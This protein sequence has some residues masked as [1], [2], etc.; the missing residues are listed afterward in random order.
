MESVP[1][2]EQ[3]SILVQWDRGP[4]EPGTA[5]TWTGARR[6]QIR[7]DDDTSTITSPLLQDLGDT[8]MG[9]P[10]TLQNFIK[11]GEQTCPA[12]H[13]MVVV[14][15]HGSGWL[16]VPYSK[17]KVQPRGVSYDDTSQ[18]FIQT[19]DIPTALQSPAPLDLVAFDASLMQMAEVA[20]QMRSVSPYIVG[21]EESPPG[22]GYAYDQWLGPLVA[23][24]NMSGKDL[25][26]TIAKLMLNYY[27]PNSNITQSV[28]KTDKLEN[29]ATAITTFSAALIP[30][31][32]TDAVQLAAARD[33]A[34]SYYYPY[35]QANKDMYSYAQL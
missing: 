21:S 11:W 16:D 8:D 10:T 14:W 4:G 6:Y 27:G 2:S 31:A 5:G 1:D 32:T 35:Y 13:Y 12:Q 30:L 29:L 25:G 22:H 28:I 17:K 9:N 24:P 33:S 7:H 34:K 26:V 23:N 19:V 15:N 18:D 3:A 20:Y